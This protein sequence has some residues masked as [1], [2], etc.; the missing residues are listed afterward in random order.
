[1][2]SQGINCLPRGIGNVPW[3]QD[4][5]P[6]LLDNVLWEMRNCPWVLGSV[7]LREK[8]PQLRNSAQNVAEERK[9]FYLVVK[10]DL[11]NSKSFEFA[12]S[13]NFFQ[14]ELDFNFS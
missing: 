9:S 7:P 2:C 12:F 8:S 3:V 10:F 11:C 13:V 14:V 4:S 1:M 5:V 6:C